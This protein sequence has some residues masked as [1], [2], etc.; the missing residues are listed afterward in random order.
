MKLFKQANHILQWES[1]VASPYYYYKA[2][3]LQLSII[4]S[5]PKC[6]CCAAPY[7]VHVLLPSLWV[8]VT[9]KP[10]SISSVYWQV[11]VL[12][13]AIPITL[14]EESLP[15]HWGNKKVIKT[16]SC[17]IHLLVKS[18]KLVKVLV[19]RPLANYILSSLSARMMPLVC[20]SPST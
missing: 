2:C 4:H 14:G 12:W 8:Y 19:F 3:F 10:L 1:L 9:I 5:A 15:H 7:G 13:S 16:S 20:I 17:L 18:W 6:N 11:S